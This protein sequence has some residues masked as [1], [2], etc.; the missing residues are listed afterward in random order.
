ML[1]YS[2]YNVFKVIYMFINNIEQVDVS[3]SFLDDTPYGK[4]PDKDSK[5]C[6]TYHKLVWSKKLPNG[7]LMNFEYGKG[8]YYLV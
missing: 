2:W 4:Y 3:K 6:Q 5:L 7:E 8:A 1:L